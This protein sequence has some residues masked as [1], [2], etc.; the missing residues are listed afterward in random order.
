LKTLKGIFLDGRKSQ[1]LTIKKDLDEYYALLN[2]TTIDIVSRKIDGVWYD[3]IC[4]DEG[5]FK[6]PLVVTAIGTDFNPELVGSIFVVAYDNKK[7]DIKSLTTEDVEHINKRI[8]DG[9]LMIDNN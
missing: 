4:D 8:F 1:V 5:L 3:I 6:E 7:G 2:C 9:T